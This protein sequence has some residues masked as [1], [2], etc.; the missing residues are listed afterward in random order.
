MAGKRVVPGQLSRTGLLQGWGIFPLAWSPQLVPA[1]CHS[2]GNVKGRTE[3]RRAEA[4]WV[5]P[6]AEPPSIPTDPEGWP[7]AR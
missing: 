4:P 5:P 2:S 3:G 1:P 6:E 7:W